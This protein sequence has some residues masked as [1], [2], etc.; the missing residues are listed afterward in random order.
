MPAN[1]LLADQAETTTDHRG[2]LAA[3]DRNILWLDFLFAAGKQR[4]WLFLYFIYPF[5]EEFTTDGN[6]GVKRGN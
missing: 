1:A 4:L 3:E 6:Y 2:H 5:C